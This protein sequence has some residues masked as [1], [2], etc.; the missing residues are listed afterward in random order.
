[1]KAMSQRMRT[2]GRL[3]RRRASSQAKRSVRPP[4]PAVL[5]LAGVCGR[6]R[7]K[8]AR[9]SETAPATMNV[10]RVAC[11][12]AGPV[13]PEPRTV[14][15]Q[16]TKPLGAAA[17]TLAQSTRMKVNGQAARIQPR[18]PPMRM[19]PNSFFGSF[20]L[21]KAMELTMDRVGT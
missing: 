2:K 12:R 19:R 16:A 14:P 21:A 13:R 11:L 9:A 8:A 4:S 18:V 20:M 10:Q 7:L 6:S 3:R 5:F 1:M 17:E 15:S